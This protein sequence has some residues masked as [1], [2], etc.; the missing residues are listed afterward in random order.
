M[1]KCITKIVLLALP[2]LLLSAAGFG[3]NTKRAQSPTATATTTEQKEKPAAPTANVVTPRSSQLSAAASPDSGEVIQW[4]VITAGVT[5]ASSASYSL[6]AGAGQPAIGES[7][8][9]SYGLTGGFWEFPYE[10]GCCVGMTG[11]VDGDP[12]ELIDIAD[13]TALIDFL[14]I[15][16]TEPECMPEANIDG[17]PEGLVDIADLTGLIDYLFIT[18]TPPANCQ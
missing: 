2:V 15:T 6:V 1:N 18:F 10:T 13:L 3:A 12:E 11:N 4:Q 16:F 14:F 7:S 8:S 5:S 9:P 17:D